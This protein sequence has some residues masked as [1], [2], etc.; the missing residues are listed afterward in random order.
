MK[1][2]YLW[3]LNAGIV[4][5]DRCY[6]DADVPDG[7]RTI[8]CRGSLGIQLKGSP[9]PLLQ[10]GT[11][12]IVWTADIDGGNVT[13]AIPCWVREAHVTTLEPSEEA[14]RGGPDDWLWLDVVAS[15]PFIVDGTRVDQPLTAT[16]RIDAARLALQEALDH[17]YEVTINGSPGWRD[18]HPDYFD[19]VCGLSDKIKPIRD[20]LL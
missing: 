17:L 8:G 13:Q 12:G 10:S 16:Q 18:F 3:T 14:A 9:V 7:I 20:R 15:G 2:A 5:V 1:R 6:V 4:P 11:T 19:L